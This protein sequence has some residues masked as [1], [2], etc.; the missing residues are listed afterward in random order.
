MEIDDCDT[1]ES[2]RESLSSAHARRYPPGQQ[3]V[4]AQF[5]PFGFDEELEET[6]QSDTSESGQESLSSS[7]R[8]RFPSLQDSNWTMPES[9]K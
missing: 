6:E 5:D 1:L 9:E 2:A 4:P 3:P 7:A 8:L